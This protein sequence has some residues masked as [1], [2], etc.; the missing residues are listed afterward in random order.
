MKIIRVKNSIPALLI[1]LSIIIGTIIVANAYRYKFR[2][3]ETI[4]VTGL[5]EKDFTSDQIVWTGNFSRTGYDLKSVYANLKSDEA[6]IKQYQ[7]SKGIQDSNMIFS[8]LDIQKLFEPKIDANGKTVGS[9]FNGYTLT[10][11]VTVDSKN[12]DGIEKLSREITDLLQK[13]I[14]FSSSAPK[15]YYTRL[16]DLKIDLLAKAAADG[17]LRAETIANNSH[18][19]LGGIKKATMGIFQIT[20]KNSNEDYSY[21][22]ALNTSSREKT[23]SITLRVDYEVQ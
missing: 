11:K 23:A 2:S 3:T 6:Q 1:A 21:G 12:I 10:G 14:E 9:I 16:N 7:N 5:A 8:S 18:A 17:R 22:G 20:G 4:S 15:Y 19:Q 13:G